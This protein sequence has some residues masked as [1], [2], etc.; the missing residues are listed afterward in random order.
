MHEEVNSRNEKFCSSDTKWV[1]VH[2]SAQ[3][4][5]LNLEQS[6]DEAASTFTSTAFVSTAQEVV[7]RWPCSCLHFLRYLFPLR[8]RKQCNKEPSES[9][10]PAHLSVVGRVS[11]YPLSLIVLVNSSFLI[12]RKLPLFHFTRMD[13]V[14]KIL[15][16]FHF[17][18]RRNTFQNVLF[19]SFTV[20]TRPS[21]IKQKTP[22]QNT[23]FSS[24]E[25]GL[26]QKASAWNLS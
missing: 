23:Y 3:Y 22:P 14:P 1:N 17:N 7:I 15:T 20:E 13:L 24:L 2:N 16:C 11:S 8:S 21:R 5:D 9:R 10:R 12:Q 6:V 18:S 4:M 25:M 26:G 19:F